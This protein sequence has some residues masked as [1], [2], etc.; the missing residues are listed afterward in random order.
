[1]STVLD[2]AVLLTA[3]SLSWF[4]DKWRS[5]SILPVDPPLALSEA[6]P[7]HFTLLSPW[8][9]DLTGDEASG[10]LRGAARGVE[11]FRLQFTSVGTFATGHVYLRPD[12]SA[13]LDELFAAL[14]EAFPEF[15]PYGG[16]FSDWLPHLTVS[17]R[18]GEATASEVRRE[19]EASTP[20]TLDVHE[21]SAWEYLPSG[22]WV[23]HL[24]VPLGGETDSATP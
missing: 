2:T 10:R 13:E 19:V 15:P 11:P 1:M 6:I 12:P 24:T 7:P 21:V 9:L 18:G 8:Y 14:T 16:A 17:R 23:R 4:T 20:L 5:R 3:E 22:R